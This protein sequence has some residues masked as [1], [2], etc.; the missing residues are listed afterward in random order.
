MNFTKPKTKRFNPGT[1]NKLNDKNHICKLPE[2]TLSSKTRSIYST[3]TTHS[4]HYRPHS[5]IGNMVFCA[6]PKAKCSQCSK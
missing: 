5:L 4:T 1:K 6:T 3:S 2:T